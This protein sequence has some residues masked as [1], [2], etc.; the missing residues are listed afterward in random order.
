MQEQKLFFL[1]LPVPK[2]DRNEPDV[3]RVKYVQFG[4][5]L[6]PYKLKCIEENDTYHIYDENKDDFAILHNYSN[7]Y[8]LQITKFSSLRLKLFDGNKR[9]FFIFEYEVVYDTYTIGYRNIVNNISKVITIE[10]N[11]IIKKSNRKLADLFDYI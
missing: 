8:Q 2:P 6:F 5:L 4:A 10:N 9:L 7:G 3:R 1:I 11:K